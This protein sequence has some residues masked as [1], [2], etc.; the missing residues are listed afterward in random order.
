MAEGSARVVGRWFGVRGRRFVRPALILTGEDGSE[1]RLLAELGDK[2]WVAADGEPW[3]ATFAVTSAEELERADRVDLSV[4]PDVNVELRRG[5]VTAEGPIIATGRVGEAPGSS[6]ASRSAGEPG[7]ASQSAGEQGPA[8]ASRTGAAPTEVPGPLPARYQR[9]RGVPTPP[10]AGSA[11]AG[12]TEPPAPADAPSVA[13]PAPPAARPRPAA[14]S[15]AADVERLTAKLR[16]AEASLERE[17]RGREEA[18]QTLERERSDARRTAAEVARLQAQ[19]ELARAA[20]RE[21][22][23]T[24]TQLDAARRDSH[25]L[26][27][28]HEALRADHERL[29]HAHAELE[30]RLAQRTDEF[31]SAGEELAEQRRQR[32]E[33]E[34]RAA[35]ALEAAAATGHRPP[36][37]HAT[38]Q[39]PPLP[40]TDRPLNPS[41]RQST[42]L[43]LL[44][45]IVIAGVL[46]AVYLVL[47]STVLH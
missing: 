21:A 43:R 25:E 36:V 9:A 45:V 29:L 38:P 35:A 27:A 30:E 33:A 15:R 28:R 19:L 2:P 6:G 40:R 47:H 8:G 5:G 3:R 18:E 1:H 17:Q 34:S 13:L 7:P 22:A 44:V 41:L 42:W 24:A 11:P 16:A 14:Q 46:L 23:D 32:Q 37:V 12:A 39:N 20:E 4:S 31:Y 26:R 10:S